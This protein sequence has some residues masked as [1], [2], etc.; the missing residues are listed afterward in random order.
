M[1][2]RDPKE[3]RA[4]EQPRRV[5]R[6]VWYHSPT[7]VPPE[8]L[9]ANRI[10]GFKM[11]AH[12]EYILEFALRYNFATSPLMKKA[13]MKQSTASV[14]LAK[15]F[16]LGLLDR[17]WHT[18]KRGM[19]WSGFKERNVGGWVYCLSQTG[20]DFLA[21]SGVDPAPKWKGDW[22]PFSASLGS[23]KL[24]I[25]HELYRNNVCLGMMESGL[26]RDLTMYWMGPRES[27]Q[28]VPPRSP[29]AKPVIIEPDS[30]IIADGVWLFIEYEQSGR[31]DRLMRKMN[32]VNRYMAVEGWRDQGIKI[33]PWIVYAVGEGRGTQNRLSGSLGGMVKLASKIFYARKRYLFIDDTS[34]N[35]GSWTATDADGNRV[36]FWE[37]VLAG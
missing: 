18:Y 5:T 28:Y 8:E 31:R 1:L 26:L 7:P 27:Y 6:S 34:W 22:H 21:L 24:S 35:A 14:R 16:N 13:G 2:F 3:N 11:S 29:G 33:P 20:F 9:I 25:T 32:N 10:K 12:D 30:V 15:L 19:D 23:K 36:P 37:T 4:I 17:M